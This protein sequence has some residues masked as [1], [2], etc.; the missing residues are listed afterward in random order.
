MGGVH[1]VE[2]RARIAGISSRAGCAVKCPAGGWKNYL[3]SKPEGWHER[4]NEYLQS[5]EWRERRAGALK[6]AGAKCQ[7]CPATSRLQ[8]HHTRYRNVGEE[9]IYE[10][11]VLCGGCHKKLH[12][13]GKRYIPMDPA[14][15]KL[16]SAKMGAL[17][18]AGLIAPRRA[19]ITEAP[20]PLAPQLAI[21]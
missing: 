9:R 18:A 20:T 3:A 4:Y 10:L 19:A 14:T 11:R 16:T 8:V 6:R 21:V 5:R 17:A 1:Q 7:L 2:R 15:E 13:T 12:G